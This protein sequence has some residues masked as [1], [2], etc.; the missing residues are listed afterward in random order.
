MRPRHPILLA[1]N[2]FLYFFF[3]I[4]TDTFVAPFSRLPDRCPIQEVDEWGGQMQRQLDKREHDRDER[5]RVR[6]HQG[7]LVREPDRVQHV[8]LGARGEVGM[9]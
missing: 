5:Q 3:A 9:H 2:R 1:A 7:G 6:G 8:L 4:L